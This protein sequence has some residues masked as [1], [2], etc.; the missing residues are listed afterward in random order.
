MQLKSQWLPK[1]PFFPE[2][3]EICLFESQL[4]FIFPFLPLYLANTASH[5]SVSL[6]VHP[7]KNAVLL[8]CLQELC[9]DKWQVAGPYH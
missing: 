6:Q 9:P 3:I 7:V 1:L 8:L 5:G 4:A 2:K